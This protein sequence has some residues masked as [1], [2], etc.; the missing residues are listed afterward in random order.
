MKRSSTI[1]LQ[2]VIV[3]IGIGVLAAMLWFPTLEGRNADATL[4]ATYFRDP[5]LAYVYIA[6]IP[7]FVAL[8]QGFKLLGS[9]GR[10][11]VFVQRSVRAL[12]TIKRCAFATASLIVGA[13][14]YIIIALGGKDDIAGAISMGIIA[15]FT[16]IVI[17]AAAAV[18]ER[19]L[20][21]ALDMKSENDLTV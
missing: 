19:V 7:F 6:S 5:F 11:D 16:C 12:R 18:F 8:Y 4:S 20:Q 1:F 14:A 15:T 2:I 21:N 3:L 13:A 9:A 10:D 17:A